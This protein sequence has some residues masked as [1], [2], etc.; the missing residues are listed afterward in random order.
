M[1]NIKYLLF[2]M[3]SALLLFGAC[4]SSQPS[5][6]FFTGDGTELLIS[7]KDVLPDWTVEDL[8]QDPMPEPD[9]ANWTVI[10]RPHPDIFG[11]NSLIFHSINVFAKKDDAEVA[12]AEEYQLS[13]ML[14][15][16]VN[17]MVGLPP[18]DLEPPEKF[19]YNSPLADKIEVVYFPVSGLDGTI[20]GY[21]YEVLARYGNVVSIF[22][23]VVEDTEQTG[24]SAGQAN[25]LPWIEV[26]KLLKTIDK[27]IQDAKLQ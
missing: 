15:A 23:T 13:S 6:F 12:L 24:I 9:A 3:L 21:R 1:S 25:V 16:Q 5:E 27:R 11:A 7:E 26:E 17:E 22:D 4:T 20:V 8:R 2:L 18:D 10:Y 14:A 19:S